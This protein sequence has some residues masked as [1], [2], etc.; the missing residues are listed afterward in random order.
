MAVDLLRAGILWEELE[1]WLTDPQFDVKRRDA[2]EVLA[3]V[4]NAAR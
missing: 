1:R 4:E 2:L 3:L